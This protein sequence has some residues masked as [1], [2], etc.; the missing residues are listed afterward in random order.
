VRTRGFRDVHPLECHGRTF[1][2]LGWWRGDRFTVYVNSAT[3]RILGV[4]PG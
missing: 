2:Y 1:A 4:G 3:G